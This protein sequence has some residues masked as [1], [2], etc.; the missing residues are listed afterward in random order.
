MGW[1]LILA[2]GL[3]DNRDAPSERLMMDGDFMDC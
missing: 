3:I 1:S 2:A